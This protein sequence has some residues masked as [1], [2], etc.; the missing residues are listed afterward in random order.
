V[1]TFWV[2]R[3]EWQHQWNSGLGPLFLV[4]FLIAASYPVFLGQGA[5]NVFL[6]GM[7]DLRHFFGSLP[8][9]LAL[10]VPALSMRCW[11]EERRL[12]TVE[13]LVSGGVTSHALVLGK[14]LG[15]F[16]LLALGL[17]LTGVVPL[18][19]SQLAALEPGHLL[20][21]YLGALLLTAASLA[22]CQWVGAFTQHQILS[23]LFSLAIFTLLLLVQHATWNFH[24]RFQSIARGV[25]DVRDFLFYLAITLFFLYLGHLNVKSSFWFKRRLMGRFLLLALLASACFLLALSLIGSLRWRV[26]LTSDKRFTLHAASVEL[27]ENLAE[28]L[29]IQLFFSRKVP[30]RFKVVQDM[31]RDL[32]REFEQSSRGRITLVELD[33]DED[34]AALREAQA[35]GIQKTRANV[36]EKGRLELAEIWLGLALLHRDRSETFPTLPPPENLEFELSSA[37][38]RLQRERIPSWLFVGNAGTEESGPP[39]DLDSAQNP[40]RMELEKSVSLSQ[41]LLQPGDVLD[42]SAADALVVWGLHAWDLPQLQALDAAILAGKPATILLSGVQVDTRHLRAHEIARSPADRMLAHYGVELARNLVADSQ[43]QVIRMNSPNG[44]VLHSYVLFPLLSQA[45]QGFSPEY[46]LTAELQSLVLPWVSEVRSQQST[47]KEVL[48]SSSQ[49]WLQEQTFLLD[50]E[51]VPGPSSFDRFCLGRQFEGTLTSAFAPEEGTGGKGQAKLLVLGTDHL[52]SQFQNP[53]NLLFFNRLA[54]IQLVGGGLETIPRAAASL[55]PIG[56]T[57]AAQRMRLQAVSLLAGPACL[58]LLAILRM[59]LRRRNLRRFHR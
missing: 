28:P 15:Q 2:A 37:L 48:F 38:L 7:V 59:L 10:F 46:P 43:C 27:V 41:V 6:S 5:G 4:L 22:V 35:Q 11:A 40:L 57:T 39:H 30:V 17:A 58:A 26:D 42:T 53:G 14:F 47:W 32:L 31:A 3:K 19:L 23:L 45:S 13:L 16:A 49:S 51:N 29:T 8:I 20:G 52:L 44:P 18:L 54:Q 21:G 1:S 56:E 33:P 55:R 12:G 50:P 36:T 25:L 9:F 24:W 34:E